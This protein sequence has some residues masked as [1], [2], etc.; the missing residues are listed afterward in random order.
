MESSLHSGTACFLVQANLVPAS[1]SISVPTYSKTSE[2]FSCHA[3]EGAAAISREL[4]TL[5][6]LCSW[7]ILF[8]MGHIRDLFRRRYSP[9]KKVCG[10]PPFWRG[11]CD[12]M[13]VV[14]VHV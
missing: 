2:M 1:Q 11:S 4:N 6:V 7:T 12:R 9:D 5:L 10:V 13:E 14:P 8:I 3:R